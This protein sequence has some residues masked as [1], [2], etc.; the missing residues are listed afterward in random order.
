MI[1]GVFVVSRGHDGDMRGPPVK[2]RRIPREEPSSYRDGRGDE[3]SVISSVSRLHSEPGEG[4]SV[5]LQIASY[6]KQ[7][8]D[9]VYIPLS[10]TTQRRLS[11]G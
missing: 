4:A 1:A 2:A 6:I 11:G 9:I 7:L 10:L 5:V 3:V 8:L